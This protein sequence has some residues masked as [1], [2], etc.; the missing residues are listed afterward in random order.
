ME[1]QTVEA[2]L[3]QLLKN[4]QEWNQSTAELS[5]ILCLNGHLLTQIQFGSDEL[6]VTQQD[7]LAQVVEK[8]QQI[9][10]EVAQ[11]KLAVLTKMRQLDQQRT[12]KQLPYRRKITDGGVI[13]L[14]Y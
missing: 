11:Q 5:E 3:K 12:V 2:Q 9:V 6:T 14:D 4:L 13:Q 7:Q 1:E 8:Y 10:E